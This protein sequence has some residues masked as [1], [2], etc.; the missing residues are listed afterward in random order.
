MGDDGLQH[1]L[2]LGL[3]VG[4]GGHLQ[5][6]VTL[7]GIGGHGGVCHGVHLIPEHLIHGAFAQAEDAQRV[8]DNLLVRQFFQIGYGAGAEHGVALLGRAG[9]HDDDLPVLFKGAARRGA[10]V[11]VKHRAA[12]R[13]HGLLKVIGGDL[14]AQIDILIQAPVLVFIP[15]QLKTKGLRQDLLCQIVTGGAQSAGG[16]DDIRPLLCHLHAVQPPGIIPHYGVV[17]HIDADLG[18]HFGDIPGVGVGHMAQQ[19]LRAHGEDFGVVGFI[20]FQGVSFLCRVPLRPPAL[21]YPAQL[22]PP[23]RPSAWGVYGDAWG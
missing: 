2:R 3:A 22:P 6:A 17:A 23:P 1:L 21:R 12:L 16:D 8:G 7:L 5:Q 15:H 10:P 19:Q 18:K 4:L 20:H 11:V 14:P 13:Q 9:D